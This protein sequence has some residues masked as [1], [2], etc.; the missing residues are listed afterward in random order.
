M[1]MAGLLYDVRYCMGIQYRP[2]IVS[3]VNGCGA[4]GGQGNVITEIF[5]R[6]EK[7]GPPKR[8]ANRWVASLDSRELP[9][10]RFANE[11]HA[12]H[13]GHGC[14]HDRIPKTVVDVAR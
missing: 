1:G 8:A 4:A 3:A 2:H 5:P 11:Q 12:D 9:V 13:E 14:H 7:N 6:C 10:L